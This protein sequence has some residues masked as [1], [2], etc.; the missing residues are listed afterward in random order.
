VSIAGIANGLSIR[1]RRERAGGPELPVDLRRP[2]YN[3]DF[4]GDLHHPGLIAIILT[5][6]IQFTAWPSCAS[7]SGARSSS[8][9]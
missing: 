3:P 8:S 5:F 1:V 6:T 9:R 7:G 4:D 2:W